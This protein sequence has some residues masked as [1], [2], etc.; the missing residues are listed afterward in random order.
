MSALVEGTQV[1]I[2]Q[3]TGLTDWV[4]VKKVSGSIFIL[5]MLSISELT[6]QQIECGPRYQG[7]TE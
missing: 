2:S 4:T 1:P 7:S 5:D 6:V 3:I